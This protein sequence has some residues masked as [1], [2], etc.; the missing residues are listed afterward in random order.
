MA[1]YE[2][3]VLRP[4]GMGAPRTVAA[5][6]EIIA[7]YNPPPTKKGGTV[8][9]GVGVLRAGEPLKY[10]TGTK[11]YIKASSDYTDAT[12][13]NVTEV[14]CTSEDHLVN[15]LFGGV[16]NA[17]VTAIK[18]KEAAL[19]TALGGTYIPQFGYIKF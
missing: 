11:S 6:E 16:I 18:T 8:K 3:N 19:A 4:P 5:P 14:D 17:R 7:S 13:V 9:A 1:E 15:I 12:C 2:G 10:D